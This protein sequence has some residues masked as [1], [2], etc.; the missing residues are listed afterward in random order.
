MATF[1][2]IDFSQYQWVVDDQNYLD[3]WNSM[4]SALNTLQGNIDTFGT[5]MNALN[6]SATQSANAASASA[7]TATQKASDASTSATNAASSASAAATSESNAAS[8]E[9]N[10]ASSASAASTSETNAASSASSASASATNAANSA[11]AAATSESNAADTLTDF[12]KRYLGA[13]SSPPTTDNS[14]NPLIVGALYYSTAIGDEGMRQWTGMQWENAY[15]TIDGVTWSGVSGK[16]ETAT[17]WPSTSEVT[18]LSTAFG[19]KR[20][21]RETV[22]S[23]T[24]S[25]T[26]TLYATH[27]LLAEVSVSLPTGPAAGDWVYVINLSGS[28]AC[29]VTTSDSVIQGG[30]STLTI[31]K[32]NAALT[33]IYIDATRGWVLA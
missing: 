29:T 12:L 14:G 32:L 10:A 26:L 4:Q 22:V 11:Q 19:A 24:T 7:D 25:R 30:D 16:P 23:V 15:A 33:L 3:K 18:G 5:D 21:T 9:S 1:P 2:T 27:A 17:R 6:A 13:K 8:S 20:D 28:E 31:D